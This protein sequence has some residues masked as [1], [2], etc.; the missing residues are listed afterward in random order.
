MLSQKMVDA[1]NEQTNKEIF[2]AYLYMSM[3]ISAN[4][5]GLKGTAHWFMVQFH[6]EMLHAMKIQEYV[7]R[8]GGKARV[9][10]I[11]EP[12]KDFE[13][14]PAIL[15]KT[16]S[17]EQLVT[18]LI[19]DLMDLAVSEKDHATRIFLQWYVS[20]QVE[21]E[22]NA[23]DILTRLKLI[24]DDKQALLMF[25]GELGARVTNV[26]TDYSNGVEAAIKGAA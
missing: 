2:S 3:S 25:D 7:Q 19:N 20:E 17:H 22:E 8:Q 9:L 18:G 26:P 6:E 24:G 5:M 14:L 10:A 15:E 16:L 4:D 11:E 23:N 12:Q 13:S 21:E 1:L